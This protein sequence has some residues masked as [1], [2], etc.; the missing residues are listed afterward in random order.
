MLIK[1]VYAKGNFLFG[2]DHLKTEQNGQQ[3]G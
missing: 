3:K 2:Q 1:T